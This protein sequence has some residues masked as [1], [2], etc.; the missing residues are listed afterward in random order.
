MNESNRQ[1]KGTS[2]DYILHL[3]KLNGSIKKQQKASIAATNK[4]FAK[5]A[6]QL[7]VESPLALSTWWSCSSAV[8]MRS[9]HPNRLLAAVR[10]LT[11]APL[12]GNDVPVGNAFVC[13]FFLV[14]L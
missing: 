9:V 14:I 3:T 1:R 13:F 2:N 12:L 7:G 11:K 4:P 10:T 6:Y 5:F 8:V